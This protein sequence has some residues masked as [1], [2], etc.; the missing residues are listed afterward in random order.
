MEALVGHLS[1]LRPKHAH[2]CQ[3]ND[4]GEADAVSGDDGRGKVF[5]SITHSSGVTVLVCL[6]TGLRYCFNHDCSEGNA[7]VLLG[8]VV[9]SEYYHPPH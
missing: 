1:L 3:H 2:H 7:I 9:D 5:R 6:C 8:D 4:N